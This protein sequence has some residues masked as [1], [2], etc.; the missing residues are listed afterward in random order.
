VF[1]GQDNIMDLDVSIGMLPKIG[2]HS[3]SV[4]EMLLSELLSR[5]GNWITV[6]L[7]GVERV[8]GL[9]ELFVDLP[10]RARARVTDE[11]L[12]DWLQDADGL[13]HGR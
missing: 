10:K 3:F 4:N 2:E 9:S 11:L 1:L 5:G 8:V 12:E 6:D 7:R 13:R